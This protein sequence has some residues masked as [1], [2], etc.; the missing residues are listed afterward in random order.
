LQ[1]QR[2]LLWREGMEIN[3]VFDRNT[4]NHRTHLV[5]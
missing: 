2:D 1:E 3:P 4:N 5:P